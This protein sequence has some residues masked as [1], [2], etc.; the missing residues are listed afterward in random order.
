MHYVIRSAMK[1]GVRL[2]PMQRSS[3]FF[4]EEP[5][6]GTT[7]LRRG[8]EIT[9]TAEQYALAETRIRQLLSAEAIIVS[10]VGDE[11]KGEGYEVTKAKEEAA[12]AEAKAK[13]EAE[14][15]AEAARLAEAAKAAEVPPEQPA[16]VEATQ[17]PAQQPEQTDVTKPTKKKK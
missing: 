15:A 8:T 4:S 2:T 9:L 17:E 7:I 10:K 3:S 5:R 13:Q 1:P 11:V 14:A 16:V 6:L 12:A